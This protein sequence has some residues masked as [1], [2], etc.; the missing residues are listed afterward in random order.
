MNKSSSVKL[1]TVSSIRIYIMFLSLLSSL[2]CYTTK[3]KE[4]IYYNDVFFHIHNSFKTQHHD[5]FCSYYKWNNVYVNPN[6][7]YHYFNKW[8]LSSWLKVSPWSWF[9]ET[10]TNYFISVFEEKNGKKW[11]QGRVIMP[12]R[13]LPHQPSGPHTVA[14]VAGF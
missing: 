10:L 8:F 2:P 1:L 14:T 5:Y 7:C 9:R 13:K 4:S 12:S 6:I 11:R 3:E